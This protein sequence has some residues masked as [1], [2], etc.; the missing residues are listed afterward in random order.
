LLLLLPGKYIKP[1]LL[2][3]GLYPQL[4]WKVVVP[5]EPCM[6]EQ[7]ERLLPMSEYVVIIQRFIETRSWMVRGRVHVLHSTAAGRPALLL[8]SQLHLRIH[9]TLHCMEQRVPYML[10]RILSSAPTRSIAMPLFGIRRSPT[11]KLYA[12]AAAMADAL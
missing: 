8:R 1:Q 6:Q 9:T 10:W 7:V 12:A 5:L 2:T 3:S 4:G 11:S